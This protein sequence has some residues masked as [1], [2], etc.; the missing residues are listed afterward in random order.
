[1]KSWISFIGSS[2][3]AVINTIWA[4]CRVDGY[5]PERVVFLVNDKLKDRWVDEVLNWVP[6][7][8][9]GYGVKEPSIDLHD[10]DETDFRSILKVYDQYIPEFKKSGQVALDITPGRKY[11]SAIG[12]QG[13]LLF[14]AEHIYYMHLKDV[15]YQNCAYPLIPSHLNSLIDMQK[16][17]CDVS[18]DRP[19]GCE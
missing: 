8:L 15:R 6:L 11:M 2:S 17:F 7:I 14:E 13:G 9:E 18:F 4:A 12:M 3:F 16:V 19:E 5:V 10:V 1:M